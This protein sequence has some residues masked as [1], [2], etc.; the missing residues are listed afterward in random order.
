M[1]RHHRLRVLLIEDDD[2]DALIIKRHVER[3]RSRMI[4]ITRASSVQ[5]AEEM[6]AKDGFDMIFLDLNVGAPL[7]G[8]EFLRRTHEGGLKT[9]VIVVT[10]AG[11][12]AKAVEAMKNG[13]YDYLV[14]DALGPDLIEQTVRAA[15]HRSVLERERDRMVE[16]LAEMSYTD[17]LT[18][19][20]NRRRLLQAL[21]EEVRRSERTGRVF[22]LLMIDLDHFKEVNDRFG[23]QTGDLVLRECA[24]TLR[25]NVRLTDL[26]ARYGGE[27]FCVILPETT[28]D[29]ACCVAEKL[30]EIIKAAL[31]PMP[32][33]SVGVACWERGLSCSD[34]LTRS[35]K[36]LYEAKTLGRDRVA[37]Y[38]E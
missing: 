18:A 33:V 21:E 26:V 25:G 28:L 14:K 10:G 23:H 36:A 16:R 1:S 6:L 11:D 17:P 27:E 24:A 3:L 13:A 8:M 34:L 32:T 7:N 9:P 31:S 29:G 15:V 12:E 37:I 22:S 19:V 2:E 30:R 38:R 4:D 35:D 5:D 20:A